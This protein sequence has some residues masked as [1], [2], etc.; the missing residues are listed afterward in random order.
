[1]KIMRVNRVQYLEAS[2]KRKLKRFNIG[3]TCMQSLLNKNNVIC[4]II[5]YFMYKNIITENM[6]NTM[7]VGC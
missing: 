1:M 6:Y 5:Y 4:C 7:G 2:E 3:N